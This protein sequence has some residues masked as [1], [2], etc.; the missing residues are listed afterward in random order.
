MAKGFRNC[1]SCKQSFLVKNLISYKG[2]N[3]CVDCLAEKK[4]REQFH[5]E[6]CNIFNLE[7]PGPFI[8]A[9]VKELTNNYG[10][11]YDTILKCLHYAFDVKKMSR[12]TL[13]GRP[14]IWVVNP[15]MVDEMLQYNRREGSHLT[16]AAIADK[17]QVVVERKIKVA[18]VEETSHN[19]PEPDWGF[20]LDDDE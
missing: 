5:S 9:R 6:L 4:L 18:P 19:I 8:Y 11:T 3:Y 14:A 7:M 16:M 12:T 2:M 15:S 1:C 20:S 13:D 10:Y 17:Q